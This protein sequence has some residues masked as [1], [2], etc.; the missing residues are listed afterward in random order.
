M[1]T[2][3]EGDPKPTFSEQLSLASQGLPGVVTGLSAMKAAGAQPEFVAHN[4]MQAAA[5]NVC[6]I[7]RAGAP[8]QYNKS[9][10]P[11]SGENLSKTSTQ[12]FLK[13]SL[14]VEPRFARIDSKGEL[15]QHNP[16]DTAHLALAPTDT[17]YQHRMQLDINMRDILR[18]VGPQG[19]LIVL[20]YDETNKVLRLGYKDGKGPKKEQFDGQFVID[21]KKRED[22]PIFYSRVWDKPE[23]DAGWDAENKIIFRPE[24]LNAIPADLYKEIFNSSFKVS[25]SETKGENLGDLHPVEVMAN[26]ARSAQDFIKDLAEKHAQYK[27]LKE[28][29]KTITEEVRVGFERTEKATNL[30]QELSKGEVTTLEDIL[31]LLK[32]NFTQAEADAIILDVYSNSSRIVAGDWDGMA[33][34]HPPGLDSKYTKVFN[35]FQAGR[36]GLVAKKELLKISTEYL[37]EIIAIANKK[38]EKLRSPFEKHVIAIAKQEGGLSAIVSEFAL[39]RAGCITVHEFVFQQVLNHAYRDKSNQYY[40]EQYKLEDAQEVMDWLIGAV[41]DPK[42]IDPAIATELKQRLKD[43]GIKTEGLRGQITDHLIAHLPKAKTEERYSLPHLQHD[44]NVHDL[45]QH[46]F[47]MRNPYGCNLEGAWLLITGDGCIVYGDNQESLVKVLLTGD[48]LEKNH[49]DVNFGADMKAG[50]GEIIKKQLELGQTVPQQTLEK[51]KEYL[52]P[53][54]PSEIFRSNLKG[55]IEGDALHK[56]SPPD[57]EQPGQNPAAA[58][59]ITTKPGGEQPGGEPHERNT[60]F[61]P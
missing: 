53:K 6:L 14:S 36:E 3:G 32:K 34:G 46:G 47:D 18:E 58:P 57:G 49:I 51:Y 7:L 2:R 15:V 37:E 29:P 45:Y 55:L 11:K 31:Q 35:T 48:F 16:K 33:L 22:T 38:E 1:F 56:S 19:D 10:S 24:A 25:Y 4:M 9:R 59:F 28:N 52:I 44:L 43:K 12:G 17:L 23:G 26:R 42:N 8:P 13:G 30:I 20:G 50:W 5:L 60:T 54:L 40:G 61:K 41:E 39:A 21:F 27:L